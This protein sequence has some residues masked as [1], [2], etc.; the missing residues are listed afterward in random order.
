MNAI[1]L[2]NSRRSIRRFKDETVAQD[3]MENIMEV[4][5]YAPSWCNYQIAR[6]TFITNPDVITSIMEDGVHGF[7]YNAK[8]L[9]HAKNVAI[10]SYVK[11]KS[12]RLDLSSDDYTTSK[13]SDWEI[14]DAGIACQQFCL[15]AHA[16]GVSTCIMGVIDDTE[17][18]QIINLPDGET[19]AAVIAYGYP[20][21]EIDKTARKSIDKLI[22]FI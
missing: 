21:E 7:A 8:T 22:R 16:H 13:S 10:L 6:Y 14:F 12:G 18:A 5:K 15:A 19:V 4:A 20:N 1:E 11:G 3:V 2:L 9:K 17:I